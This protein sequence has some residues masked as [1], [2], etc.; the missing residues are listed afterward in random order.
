M[1][2]LAVDGLRMHYRLVGQGPPLVMIMGLSGDI[3]WWGP[4][5]RELKK[6][7]EILLFDNRGAG[8][9]DKPE[10]K[11]TIPMCSSLRKTRKSSGPGFLDP[12]WSA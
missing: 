5:V 4:L 11:Y 12:V 8:R 3:T 7:F 1:P 10:E 9:T 6:S 2:F